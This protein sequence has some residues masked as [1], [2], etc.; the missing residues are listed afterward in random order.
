M[1]CRRQGIA[2]GRSRVAAAVYSVRVFS[3]MNE[4]Y[5]HDARLDAVSI[6]EWREKK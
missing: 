5:E 1:S 4:Q 3:F 6:Q 2:L